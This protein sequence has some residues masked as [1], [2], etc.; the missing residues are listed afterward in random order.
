M[1]Y[2]VFREMEEKIYPVKLPIM[3]D[4]LLKYVEKGELSVE[5]VMNIL[6]TKS[7]AKA[8]QYIHMVKWFI[9]KF[10]KFDGSYRDFIKILEDY[11]EE[12][13]HLSEIIRTLSDRKLPANFVFLKL[14]AREKN[15]D[16]DD[17]LARALFNFAKEIGILSILNVATYTPT[18]EEKL[19]NFIRNRGETRFSLL[20]KRFPDTRT[21]VLKLWRENLIEIEGLED[22]KEELISF[23]DLDHI[24]ID[25]VSNKTDFFS[26]WEDPISGKQF[27]SLIIPPRAKV[28]IKWS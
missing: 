5:D 4:L 25:L 7:V 13:Y 1:R 18:I 14:V 8:R 26:I 3:Y 2:M 17:K 11:F 23:E 12:N 28:K 22:I 15:L 16:I 10:G 6:A 20:E 24:P 19:L 27:A 21:L 9:D